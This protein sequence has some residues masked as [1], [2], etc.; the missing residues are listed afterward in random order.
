MVIGTMGVVTGHTPPLSG[1]WLMHFAAEELF[2][3]VATE[4]HFRTFGTKETL[5]FDSVGVVAAAAITVRKRR[6]NRALFR[7]F[8]DLRVT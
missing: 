5:I 3:V 6:M 1:E 2:T 4:A 8:L 7:H